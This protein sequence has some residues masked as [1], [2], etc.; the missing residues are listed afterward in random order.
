MRYSVRET[1]YVGRSKQAWSLVFMLI[2]FASLTVGNVIFHSGLFPLQNLSFSRYFSL[3]M[4]QFSGFSAYF[5]AVVKACRTDLWC[6]LFIA[7]SNLARIPKVI[8][9][10][11]FTYRSFLFGF[12]GA[13]LISGIH[14]TTV[15]ANE[16]LVWGLFFLYHVLLFA[17]LI[18][19][20]AFTAS[21]NLSPRS[22]KGMKYALTVCCELS[23][24]IFMNMVYYFLIS[25]I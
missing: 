12:C 5:W 21:L 16:F 7:F 19:F 24:V 22:F 2:S 3:E 18:C 20:G 4:D 8:L 9:V 11:V 17:I 10:G 23:L 25:K 14:S 15:L 13:Y 6:V 1:K